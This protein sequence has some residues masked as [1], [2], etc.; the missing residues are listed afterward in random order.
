MSFVF[1]LNDDYK[2]NNLL[3]WGIYIYI[4]FFSCLIFFFFTHIPIFWMLSFST[5]TGKH[6]KVK[7]SDHPCIS[8]YSVTML[9]VL[10]HKILLNIYCDVSL[11]SSKPLEAEF[12]I[13]LTC[14]VRN[15]SL[16][17]RA[18]EI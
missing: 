13:I 12:H 11:M 14:N 4:F 3:F 5:H 17:V 6:Q 2:D 10:C 9:H 16:E 7:V 15:V 1:P 8:M 18:S